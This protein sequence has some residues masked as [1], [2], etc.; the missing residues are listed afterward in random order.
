MTTLH[1]LAIDIGNTNVKCALWDGSAWQRVWR[2]QTIPDNLAD[3]YAVF[4]RDFKRGSNIGG[5]AIS[6]VVPSLT[7]AFA[8]LSRRHL[9]LEPFIITPTAKTGLRIAL[10]QPEQVGSDRLANAA[11]AHALYGTPA[12]VIDLGT[13]TKFEAIGGGGVYKGGAI[14]P[15]ITAAATILTSRA[16]LLATAEIGAPPQPIG[17]NTAAALQSGIFWGSV[18]MV[19]LMLERMIAALC[20]ER[21]Q[22]VATGGLSSLIRHH[23][24]RIDVYVPNLTL[25]GIRVIYEINTSLSST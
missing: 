1:L 19:D 22:V 14:A 24:S 5:V 20:E 6:S 25:D 8:E 23:V 7:T 17:T 18:A 16:E 12:V 21:V 2:A 4:V 13:A 3:D 15:S 9:H 10:D 11:A